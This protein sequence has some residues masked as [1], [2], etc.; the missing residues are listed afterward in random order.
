MKRAVKVTIICPVEID[1][2]IDEESMLTEKE[3]IE[4]AESEVISE[5]LFTTEYLSE[6]DELGVEDLGE[7]EE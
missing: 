7:W 5:D 6:W 1:D 3:Q 2:D 4:N